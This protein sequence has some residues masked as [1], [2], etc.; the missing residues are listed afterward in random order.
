MKL[1]DGSGRPLNGSSN[2]PTQAVPVFSYVVED[3]SL[4][5]LSGP[6]Q[7]P[8]IVA[9]GSNHEDIQF[10]LQQ[11]ETI[12]W[13]G[14]NPNAVPPPGLWVRTFDF[15][16]TAKPSLLTAVPSM[17]FIHKSYRPADLIDFQKHSFP[18][19]FATDPI[20]SILNISSQAGSEGQFSG[21]LACDKISAFIKYDCGIS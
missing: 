2:P 13:V 11:N 4:L 15:K 9:L 1:L 5:F 18:V 14:V 17:Q 10:I 7:R 8:K 12:L 19:P 21:E 3:C 20:R 6:Y 16:A